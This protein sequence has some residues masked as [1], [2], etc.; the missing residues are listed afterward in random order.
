LSVE[1]VVLDRDGVLNVEDPDGGYVLS[2][3][4]FV[5]IDGVLSAI[6]TLREAG[7]EL[8]VVTNQ[9][10]VGRGLLEPSVLEAIHDRIRRE[11][12]IERV[13]HCPHAPDEG[14]DCRKPAP[15]LLLQAI[16]DS[17]IAADKTIF[18]G[19]AERDLEAARAAGVTPYLVRTGKGRTTEAALAEP[20]PTFD[21]LRA[22]A[23]SLLADR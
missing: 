23:R 7:F 21:D 6:Q 14:C 15:G 9:S 4:A 22:L 10:A 13:Y 18:V 11:A 20:V 17:G 8:S 12:G 3:E 5:W 19:D 1:H 16:R 2:P